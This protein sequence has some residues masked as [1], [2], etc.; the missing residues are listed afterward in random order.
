MLCR[1]KDPHNGPIAK[2]VIHKTK[3][4]I[5]EAQKRACRKKDE[6]KQEDKGKR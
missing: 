3:W 6:K 2:K 1:K 5:F 4:I